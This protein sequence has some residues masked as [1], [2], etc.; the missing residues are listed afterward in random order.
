LS[1]AAKRR[2]ACGVA[3]A[4]GLA[5]ARA[6]SAQACP[7][8]TAFD[9][10]GTPVLQSGASHAW[11]FVIR[12]KLVDADGAPNAYSP[13]DAGKGCPQDGVGLDCAESA[14]YP[15]KPWWP[16][17][18]VRD[19][20]RPGQAY[21]QTAGPYRG[22]FVSQTTL[23]RPD[24]AS[25][26]SPGAF[27]DA[28]RVPYLVMPAP[29]RATA[30]L[31]EIGDVGYAVNLRTGRRS[32]FVI[33]DEGPLEPLGEAS[34]AFWGDIGEQAPNPRDGGGLPS[35]PVAVVVFPNSGARAALGWPIDDRRLQAVGESLLAGVGG[36]SSLRSCAEAASD[37]AA[38]A[39]P[40]PP[41]DDPPAEVTLRPDWRHDT[42]TVFGRRFD[43]EAG[44]EAA[45][46]A[47]HDAVPLRFKPVLAAAS[48]ISEPGE[49]GYQLR[50][51]WPTRPLG[52][53]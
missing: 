53:W 39:D 17:V 46:R 44:C 4:A 10:L 35:D 43:T 11:F 49:D 29:L 8:D 23:R 34:I 52:A 16:D 2:G 50:M 41:V 22:F 36:A 26:Y 38:T 48:C 13:E 45:V 37:L 20:D 3:L 28:A 19:P 31:G 25:I 33:A 30:G 21:V 32:A 9:Y 42:A 12:D 1:A 18:L 40:P 47:A 27:V 24:L 5:A 14:G 6:A 15:D 51:N 7:A